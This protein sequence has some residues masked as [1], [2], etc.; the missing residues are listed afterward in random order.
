[1]KL[2]TGVIGGKLPSVIYTNS[3]QYQA[4]PST[5][6]SFTSVPFGD[7][8]T[9]RLL[10]A[11]FR[12]FVSSGN[13]PHACSI[14]GVSATLVRNSNATGAAFRQM[15]C[16]PLDAGTSGTITLTR[17]ANMSG[18]AVVVWAA[19]DLKSHTPYDTA[20]GS[21]AHPITAGVNV[22]S[23]GIVVGAVAGGSDASLSWSGLTED[24]EEVFGPGGGAPRDSGA[25]LNRVPASSPL[26]VT[27]TSGSS[28]SSNLM[29]A[30]WR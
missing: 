10:I 21:F 16:A 2:G 22:Q 23:N 24:W 1:M 19:Y 30:S 4:G 25:S 6:L 12:V 8:A 7:A 15:W 26:N 28:T 3:H 9:G 14:G 17:N 20:Y 11:W 18:G 13:A 27:V 29:L 5:T